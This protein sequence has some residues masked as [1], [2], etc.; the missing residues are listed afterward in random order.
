MALN[1]LSI[2]VTSYMA[3][4]RVTILW[5]ALGKESIAGGVS[6]WLCETAPSEGISNRDTLGLVCW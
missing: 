4:V 1:T 3:R 5:R 6:C 2:S